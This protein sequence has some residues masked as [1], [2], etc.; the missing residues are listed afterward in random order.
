MD[1]KFIS[2][3]SAKRFS[4]RVMIDRA[5]LIQKFKLEALQLRYKIDTS[6]SEEQR[7]KTIKQYCQLVY[8]LLSL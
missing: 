7:M 4:R 6:D 2:V 5:V 3:L 8:F 1:W